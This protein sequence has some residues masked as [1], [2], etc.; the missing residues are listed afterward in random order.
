MTRSWKRFRCPRS[1][2]LLRSVLQYPITTAHPG[3][4]RPSSKLQRR[5]MSWKNCAACWVLTRPIRNRDRGLGRT[6]AQKPLENVLQ[7]ELHDSRAAAGISIQAR[8]ASGDPAKG[9]GITQ[10]DAGVSESDRVSDVERS[11]ERRVG[12]EWRA[13]GSAQE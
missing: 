11:E 6:A 4:P 12:K 5:A 9:R 3:W 7:R 13:R 2:S 1:E 10:R 8:C